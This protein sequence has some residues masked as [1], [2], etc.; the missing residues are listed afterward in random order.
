MAHPFKLFG[1]TGR[2]PRGGSWARRSR[3][4]SVVMEIIT[5]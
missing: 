3:G 5:L 4:R 1:E 2:F